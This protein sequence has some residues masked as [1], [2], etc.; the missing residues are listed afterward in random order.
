MKKIDVNLLENNEESISKDKDSEILSNTPTDQEQQEDQ[1]LQ[2]SEIPSVSEEK[3]EKTEEP[4]QEKKEKEEETPHTETIKTSDLKRGKKEKSTKKG[5]GNSS[6]PPAKKKKGPNILFI[7]LLVVIVLAILVIFTFPKFSALVKK[8]EQVKIA[9]TTEFSIV[10][11]DEKEAR[12]T[13]AQIRSALEQGEQVLPENISL[14]KK[15]LAESKD[16]LHRLFIL[17]DHFPKGLFWSYYSTSGG[18]ELFE[19][20]AREPGIFEMFYNRVMKNNLFNTLKFYSYDGKYWDSLEGVFVGTYSSTTPIEKGALYSM[21]PDDF[22]AYVA[23]SAQTAKINFTDRNSKPGKSVIPRTKQTV[24]ELTFYGTINQLE[25]FVEEFSKI[26][27]TF[28]VSK[29]IA[30]RKPSEQYPDPLK[31]TLFVALYEKM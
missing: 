18:F 8:P 2:F 19:V 15:Q 9:K 17:S 14:L 4:S 21:N 10:P 16:R 1:N 20:K 29:V 22:I 12:D 3:L 30:G 26:P 11:V 31:L 7:V 28:T 23:Y 24:L 5:G 6:K 25:R 27:A 13:L